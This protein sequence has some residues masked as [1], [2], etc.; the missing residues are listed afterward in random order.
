LKEESALVTGYGGGKTFIF[1]RKV[2]WAH[3]NL[4]NKRGFSNGWVIYPTYALAEELFIEQFKYLLYI[5][6]IKYKYTQQHHVFITKYGRIRV[7]QLQ[8]P[9][10]MVGS[11][12][13]FCGFDE[14]DVEKR[15]K[16]L[17][18]YDK[19]VGRMRGC[20]TPQLFVVTTP[21]GFRATHHIFVEEFN[22]SKLLIQ[23]S[24]R[25]NPYREKG[26]IA[27]MERTYTPKLVEAYVDGQ[28][29]NLTSGSVY[30]YFDRIK[31]H[32]DEEH[33]PNENISIG[34]DFNF[35]GCCSSVFVERDGDFYQVSE[36]VSRDTR[37]IIA[38]T[39][40]LFPGNRVEFF[41]DATGNNESTNATSSDIALL[42]DAGFRVSA[43]RKNPRIQDR[44]NA[45]NSALYQGVYKINTKKCPKSVKAL[46]QQAYDK[47]TGKPEK[48]NEPASPDDWNDSIG[49]P[50][51]YKY[52]VVSN[53]RQ[54]VGIG[55]I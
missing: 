44:V 14:F 7:F 41:P 35:G 42:E 6:G 16:V 15:E 43:D 36:F 21:E 54:S 23:G 19:A 27:R 52:P 1:L 30:P 4:K 51:A 13:T 8:R 5:N 12:L 10:L 48:S 26:Y 17:S 39:N 55:G 38:N 18:A 9:E 34:Q 49:Y 28:F 45:V 29:V 50:I 3:I 47:K 32:T 20:E 31:S 40:L 22:N 53:R 25:D 24:T 37:E 46:T 2:L 33:T 11:E